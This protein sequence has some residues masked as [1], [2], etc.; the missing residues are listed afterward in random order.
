[1]EAVIC[2]VTAQLLNN[3]SPVKFHNNIVLLVVPPE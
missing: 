1:M 2:P 3:N